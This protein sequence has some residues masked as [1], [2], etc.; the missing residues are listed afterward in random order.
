MAI[1]QQAHFAGHTYLLLD[2]PTGTKWWA[3]D[4]A[5][6]VALGGHLATIQQRR[7]NAFIINKFIGP[8]AQAASH[9]PQSGPIWLFFGLTDKASEGTFKWASGEA[10][11]YTNWQSGQPNADGIADEDFAAFSLTFNVPGTW[12]TIVGDTRFDDRAFGIAE[13]PFLLGTNNAEE[14]QWNDRQGPYPG[15]SA[16]TIP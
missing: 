16:A 7:K 2:N 8:A 12:Y 11:T 1:L 5:E 4:E 9:L 15:E 10:L 6:A 13:L 3:G 14:H